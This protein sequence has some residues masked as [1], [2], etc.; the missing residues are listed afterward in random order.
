MNDFFSYEFRVFFPPFYDA[1]GVEI[2]NQAK[3]TAKNNSASNIRKPKINQT[4]MNMIHK[5]I[6]VNKRTNRM[7][8]LRSMC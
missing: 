7:I 2:F 3:A 6:F 4:H 1:T 5:K 8:R